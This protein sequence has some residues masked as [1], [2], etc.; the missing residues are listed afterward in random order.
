MKHVLGILSGCI[1]FVALQFAPQT[2]LAVTT[3]PDYFTTP[4]TSCLFAGQSLTPGQSISSP[5][6]AYTLKFETNGDLVDIQNSDNTVIW[7]SKTTGKGGVAV[8]G[9]GTVAGA[10]IASAYMVDS[11]GNVLWNTP[12]YITSDN[13]THS[14]LELLDSGLVIM[15]LATPIW[16]SESA[17][18]PGGTG[19]TVFFTV[20]QKIYPGTSYTIGPCELAFQQ[21]DGNMVIY[22]NGSPLWNTNT[23]N[24]GAAFALLQTDLNFVVYN[25]AMSPLWYSNTPRSAPGV[26][27]QSFLAFQPDCNFVEYQIQEFTQVN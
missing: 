11:S 22:G 2:A 4:C 14:E 7:D 9:P 19:S 15:N 5:S 26:G 25:S 12:E 10:L 24:Q 6:G 23:A 16:Q 1:A 13:R 8:Y 21:T 20:G 3:F 18:N 27:Q 17:A